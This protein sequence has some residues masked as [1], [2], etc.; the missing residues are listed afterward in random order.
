VS[1]KMGHGARLEDGVNPYAAFALQVGLYNPS[2][3]PTL[4][5]LPKKSVFLQRS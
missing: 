5:T 1:G 2:V 3:L 4:K